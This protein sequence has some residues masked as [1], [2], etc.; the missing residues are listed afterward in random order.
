MSGTDASIDF[1]EQSIA[2]SRQYNDLNVHHIR[3]A[4]RNHP[5]SLTAHYSAM[6][7]AYSNVKTGASLA[8][9]FAFVA[10]RDWRVGGVGFLGSAA[11]GLY[12]YNKLRTVG[13]TLE[14][15]VARFKK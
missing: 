10:M 3:D 8:V 15:E 2:L 1:E 12:H 11:F 9:L 5:Q 6:K 7:D 4:Y 13:R 14:K